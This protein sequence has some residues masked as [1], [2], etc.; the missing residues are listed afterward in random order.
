MESNMPDSYLQIKKKQC[1]TKCITQTISKQH[2]SDTLHYLKIAYDISCCQYNQVSS[3]FLF[4][5]S[6]HT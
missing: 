5:S 2:K 6:E 1:K 3:Q 4:L